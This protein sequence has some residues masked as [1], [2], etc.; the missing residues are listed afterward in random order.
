MYVEAY[1]CT[2]A[3]ESTTKT[4]LLAHC[5]EMAV[6][7]TFRPAVLRLTMICVVLHNKTGSC[8]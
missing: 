4:A 3:V 7:L 8:F 6:L 1:C 2:S 5:T